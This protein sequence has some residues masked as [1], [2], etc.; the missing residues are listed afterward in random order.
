MPRFPFVAALLCTLVLS[1]CGQ[2]GPLYV[3]GN[4]SRIPAPPEQPQDDATSEQDE[5]DEKSS[6]SR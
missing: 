6:G 3:P 1:A 2:S 5:D 4:P